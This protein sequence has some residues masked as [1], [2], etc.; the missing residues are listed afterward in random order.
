M[1]G[2]PKKKVIIAI[3]ESDCSYYAVEWALANLKSAITPDAGILLFT[4]ISNDYGGI[5]AGSYGAALPELILTIQDNQK[6]S[7][8]ALLEKAKEL[9][10]KHGVADAETVYEFGNPKEAICSAVDKYHAKLLVMGSHSKGAIQRAFLGSVSNYCVNN[11]KCP[12]MV[13]RKPAA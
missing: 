9:C 8:I 12:V 10:A 3:D 11:A 1:E 4:V 5:I 6:K 13:V 2:E 7:T